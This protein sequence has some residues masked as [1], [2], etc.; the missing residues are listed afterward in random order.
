MRGQKIQIESLCLHQK[1]YL[2]VSTL[3]RSVNIITTMFTLFI[4]LSIVRGATMADHAPDQ[5]VGMQA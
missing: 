4:S 3:Y 2:T 1:M 5:E